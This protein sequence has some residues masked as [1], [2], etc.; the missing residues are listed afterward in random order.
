MNIALI[1]VGVF[2]IVSSRVF[3][4]LGENDTHLISLGISGGMALISG[5]L[6]FFKKRQ[7]SRD[8]LFLKKD[9]TQYWKLYSVEHLFCFICLRCFRD[10]HILMIFIGLL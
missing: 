1:L 4:G 2:L 10:F 8:C 6:S 7:Y 5:V 9:S 3:Y